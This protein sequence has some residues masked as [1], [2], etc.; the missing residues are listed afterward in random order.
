M[1]NAVP[2]PTREF[3]RDEKSQLY[4]VAWVGQFDL[5]PHAL[6]EP[7]VELI[8]VP[9][10]EA[11]VNEA[12]INRKA[13]YDYGGVRLTR[14][15]VG[16]LTD[17]HLGA[18]I[19][20]RA[21]V[22]VPDYGPETYAL[23]MDDSHMSVVRADATYRE[24][25][26]DVP[27]IPPGYYPLPA[28]AL[29]SRCLVVERDVTDQTEVSR[30]IFPCSVLLTSYFGTS[31]GLIKEVVKGG[32][33]ADGNRI[34]APDRTGF[35]ADGMAYVCLR[36]GMDDHDAPAIARFAHDPDICEEVQYIHES[37]VLNGLNGEG[38][39][40]VV[41]P[42]FRGATTMKLHG[43]R[44][45]SGTRWH[46]LVFRI[47]DCTGPYPYERLRFARDNDGRGNGTKDP[48]RPEAYKESQKSPRHSSN[49]AEE[50]EMASDDEPSLDR[51]T[52]EIK[53]TGRRF[54]SMPEDIEKVEKIECRFRAAKRQ[55]NVD[56]GETTG[57]STADGDHGRTELDRARL[58]RET[59]AREDLSDRL[60]TFL[61]VL[62]EMGRQESAHLSYRLV[63]VPPAAP[64]GT[65]VSVFPDKSRGK[66]LSWSFLPGPPRTRRR[67]IVA[68][69]RYH[70][71]H[72]YLF[73]AE[74]RPP[75]GDS[76]ESITT[77][78]VHA[79]DGTPLGEG[80]LARILLHG[81]RNRGVWLTDWEWAELR[82]QKLV[83]QS[84]AVK[85]FAERFVEYFKEFIPT[86]EAAPSMPPADVPD[87]SVPNVA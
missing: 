18:F 30:V 11:E 2:F 50:L 66:T 55:G 44:I 58:S 63:P 47:E 54:S 43:K 64:D 84:V 21:V 23:L 83:H 8:L 69:V 81:A 39:M 24:G 61:L 1:F 7:T 59:M 62:A 77:L 41:R 73:E 9:Y 82:R 20:D 46:F 3:P 75:V 72:F 19:R 48:D 40:P 17:L 32:M 51:F 49:K 45:K 10:L 33:A 36:P 16:Q 14:V 53:L 13:F 80:M 52:T 78:I 6:S 26:A 29:S 27:Y 31:S 79:D 71:H 86:E 4:R 56:D 70:G 5:N 12:T 67:V 35:D 87:A 15:G 28:E 22:A 60:A 74:K 37:I 68:E 57:L 76:D 25:G 85:R 65:G 38:Y 42:P 34:F